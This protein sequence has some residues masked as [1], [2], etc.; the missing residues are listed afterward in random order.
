MHRLQVLASQIVCTDDAERQSDHHAQLTFQATAG[1]VHHAPH[2]EPSEPSY[3]VTLPE[4]LSA[5][6]EWAVRRCAGGARKAACVATEL[7][8]ITSVYPLRLLIRIHNHP[9]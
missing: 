3:S 9:L 7:S 6:G 2:A 8:G 1:V 4:H 5:E